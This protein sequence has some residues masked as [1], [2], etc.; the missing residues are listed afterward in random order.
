M[1][2]VNM[3]HPTNVAIPADPKELFYGQAWKLSTL[4]NVIHLI[5]AR[6]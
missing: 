5:I 6:V 1:E 4:L 3:C 2:S